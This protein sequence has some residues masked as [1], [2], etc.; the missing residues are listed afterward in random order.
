L[1]D[2]NL[3]IKPDIDV[4]IKYDDTAKEWQMVFDSSRPLNK[5]LTFS[6]RTRGLVKSPAKS[7][8]VSNC[9]KD[10]IGL[11]KSSISEYSVTYELESKSGSI[12]KT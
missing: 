11:N 12:N 8:F 10:A 5:N 6:G 3:S 9:A 2:E 4:K 1:V 7:I